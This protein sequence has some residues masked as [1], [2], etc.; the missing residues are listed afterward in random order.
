VTAGRAFRPGGRAR[1]AALVT[2]AAG[3]LEVSGTGAGVPLHPHGPPI[4]HTGGFGEP[5]C[6]ACHSSEELNAP[7]GRLTVEG[8]PA[9]YEPGRAYEVRILLT[10]VDMRRAGF[11]FTL[12]YAAGD[13]AGRQAGTVEASLPRVV[14][15]TERSSG[16]RYVQQTMEGSALGR[17]ATS[18][19]VR[20]VAPRPALGPVA[21]HL[22]A[23][24]GNDDNSPIGDYVYA[25]SV[26]AVPT[27]P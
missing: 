16:V 14:V 22:A 7:G 3:A 4:G 13:S 12:R 5:T 27:H 15:V 20:W 9:S 10:R 11:Q 8:L 18:W 25:D 24:A 6:H 19:T 2:L 26:R 23:N 1:I 21:L 17:G